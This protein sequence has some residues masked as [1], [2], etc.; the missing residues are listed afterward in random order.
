M[1]EML[2]EYN[3][4]V[5]RLAK[6]IASVPKAELPNWIDKNVN[7]D[8]TKIAWS[9]NLKTDLAKLVKHNF[10]D[11]GMVVAIYRP[12]CRQWVYF[13]RRLNERVYHIPRLFPTP[14]HENRAIC[15]TAVGNRVDFSAIIT[16]MLPD[17]HM[18]DKNGASQ[19][20]PLY[21]YEP[22]DAARPAKQG[23]LLGKIQ[24]GEVIHGYRR[25]SAI[26]DAILADFRAAYDKKL[27]KEDIF[28]YVYGILHSPEYRTRFA[29][30]LKKMLPRI[31]LTR[32][33]VD[34]FRFSKAGREL[35][36]LHLHYETIDPWPLK[37]HSDRLQLDPD[38][39]Y[40]VQKMTFARKNKDTD[41]TAIVYNAHLTLAGIP[42]EA[43]EYVV[44]G[45]PAIEWVMERYQVTR[46][47]DSGIVN[48][49]NDWAREH[50]QPR[51]IVDL[52][53]RVVRVSIETMKIV[54]A[55]PA[56]N[57]RRST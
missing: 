10:N 55:L 49:P 37:E 26:T 46:D 21:L 9:V 44:N 4:H 12:F 13:D 33:T 38:K 18:A 42:L 28:Y 57:E 19:C 53:K 17:L 7:T 52:L 39:D 14:K 24:S 5:A 34:F 1:Q 36:D 3:A 54:K 40:I 43:Y 2:A 29:S 51:Y 22:D 20:L 27:T 6:S 48:D 8:S 23:D 47:K 45:K 16:D 56:L 30:D 11:H 50:G 35:A 41:K 15:V 25:R 32:D 31:P